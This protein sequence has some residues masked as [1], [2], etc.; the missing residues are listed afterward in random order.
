VNV[1]HDRSLKKIRLAYLVTHPIQYQAPLLKQ[2]AAQSDIDLTVFFCSDISMKDYFDPG[3]GAKVKWDVPLLEGYQHE[4]LPAIGKK[5]QITFFRP[6]NYGLFKRLKQGKFD[7]LWIHGYF[8]WINW[9]AVIWAKLL[10]IKVFIRD[11]VTDVSKKRSVLKR[12][13]KR[14]FFKC[15]S[16]LVDG[17]LAIGT[18]NLQFYLH[19][20]ISARKIFWAP[21]TVDNQYFQQKIALASA[22]RE[23]LRE[24]LQISPGRPIILFASKLQ[25]RK[26]ALDLLDAYVQL[27]PDGKQEPDAYLLFIGD[28]EQKPLLE[29]RIEAL[30]WSSIKLLGFKNQSELPAYYDLAD[31][32]VLPSYHEPWGL[33]INEAMNAFCAIIAASEVGAAPDLVKPGYNG[34]LFQARDIE[35]LM[36]ALTQV[37]KDYSVMGENSLALINQWSFNETILGVKTAFHQTLSLDKKAD[38][39][40]K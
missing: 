40:G 39:Y 34:A 32:F 35:G 2:L 20:G 14:V 8:R 7:V 27:S 31:I 4:F 22:S 5:D 33:V 24:Q 21:Y 11:E 28:G 19:Q 15:F 18:L 23:Y 17:Y 6:L 37:L 1:T 25:D 3:F 38:S 13:V 9:V 36:H 10:G 29:K 30:G 12:A 26:C 16:F